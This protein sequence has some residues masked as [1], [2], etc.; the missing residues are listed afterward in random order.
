MLL[1][2]ARLDPR[3]DQLSWLA[4]QCENAPEHHRWIGCHIG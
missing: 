4:Q 1:A 3:G 2:S